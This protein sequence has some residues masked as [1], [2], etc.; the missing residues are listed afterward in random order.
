MKPYLYKYPI[1]PNMSYNDVGRLT[2]QRLE[3]Q[4]PLCTL[5][6]LQFRRQIFDRPT[7]VELRR[8]V[9]RRVNLL[10]PQQT[11]LPQFDVPHLNNIT[12][13]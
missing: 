4:N 2:L 3:K 13:W 7:A 10:D 12:G 9:V 11:F 8:G 5:N 6:G 1:P